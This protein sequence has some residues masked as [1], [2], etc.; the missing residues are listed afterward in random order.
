MSKYFEA[1]EARLASEAVDAE[2]GATGLKTWLAVE[3]SKL[4]LRKHQID[5]MLLHARRSI[6]QTD[7]KSIDAEELLL[8]SARPDGPKLR[9]PNGMQAHG[10]FVIASKAKRHTLIAYRFE[11][12]RTGGAGIPPFVRYDFDFKPHADPVNHPQAHLHPGHADVRVPAPV[13][14]PKELLQW[15]LTM[16]AWPG[17]AVDGAMAALRP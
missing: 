17:V 3:L 2:V 16:A 13:L 14:R 4:G 9:M 15:F 8:G 5:S 11:V 12:A 7:G 10:K 6:A 1:L